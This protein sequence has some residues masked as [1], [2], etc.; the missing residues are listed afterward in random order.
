MLWLSL[1][2]VIQRVNGGLLLAVSLTLLL[3]TRRSAWH[4]WCQLVWTAR[5][6]LLSL[7]LIVAWGSPG[8]P[9]WQGPLTPSQE[10]L[11]AALLPL[12][13]LLLTLLVVV[14]MRQ[15]MP[16]ADLLSALYRLLAPLR[17]LGVDIAPGIV[18]L[19]LVMRQL[20]TMPR[21]HDWRMLFEDGPPT[22]AEVFEIVD[23]RYS[24]LDYLVLLAVVGGLPAIFL[25]PV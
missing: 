15:Q 22:P 13:R 14:L 11:A 4:G 3:F 18:R 6:L 20:D 12:E 25:S 8:E 17:R 16:I 5:W 19:L 10:G 7:F 24:W 21:M 1:L 2:I 9:V 23:R